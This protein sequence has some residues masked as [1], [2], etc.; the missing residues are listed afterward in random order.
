MAS[1]AVVGALRVV[2]GADTAQFSAG[3]KKADSK[4]ASF[5]KRLAGIGVVIAASVAAAAVGLGIAVRKTITDIDSLGKTAQKIGIPVEELSKLQYA[6]DLSGVSMAQLTTGVGR[7]SQNLEE[8]ASTGGGEAARVFKALGIEATDANGQL[9]SSTQIISEVADRFAGMRDGAEKTAFAMELFGRSGRDMIPLLNQGSAGLRDMMQEAEQLGLV[10]SDRT[11]TASEQFN[12]NLNRLGKVMDGVWNEVVDKLAPAL[13]DL[14]TR[15]ANAAKEGMLFETAGQV[16]ESAIRRITVV[17]IGAQTTFERLGAS[18][19]ALTQLWNTYSFAEFQDKWENL[20]K[21]IAENQAALAS[22]SERADQYLAGL[23]TIGS[24]AHGA[25][26]AFDGLKTSVT[27]FLNGLPVEGDEKHAAMTAWSEQLVADANKWAASFD[28]AG[29]AAR[30][31][32]G[33]VVTSGPLISKTAEQIDNSWSTASASIAGSFAN[34]S[35]SFGRESSAMAKAAQVAGAAQALIQAFV[36]ASNALASG[37]FPANLAAY[38]AVLAQGLSAVA[39]I[40]AVSVPG[41]A[42]GGSFTVPG[43]MSMVDDHRYLIDLASGENV[44]VTRSDQATVGGGAPQLV[45]L[46]LR[47]SISDL[48]RDDIRDVVETLNEAFADGYKLKVT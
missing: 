3:L 36:G 21:V 35:Q 33:A 22:I 40:K 41:F 47:G 42:H 44:Q 26:T 37:L 34:A 2:L 29:N 24:G 1:N 20:K 39:S 43:G 13:S 38:A 17:V 19:S 18:W 32:T 27:E 48:I 15:L 8:F 5:G 31:F 23:N 10:I 9:K 4:L 46:N 12:D 45:E 11:F 7:L 14:T 16:V 28:K 25:K 30:G 6:A